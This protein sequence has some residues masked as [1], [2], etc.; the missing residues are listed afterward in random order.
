MEMPVSRYREQGY[1]PDADRLPDWDDL[2]PDARLDG[3]PR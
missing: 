3:A 2:S 1:S